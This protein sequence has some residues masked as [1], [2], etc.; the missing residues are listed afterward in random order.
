MQNVI[1]VILG[2]GR[3]TRLY[4]LTKDC[5]K[6]NVQIAGKFWLIDIP[7]FFKIVE[8]D[9]KDKPDILTDFS[10]AD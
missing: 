6:P 5:V 1:A 7:A 2:G 4:P 9:D 10:R 3:G 8:K